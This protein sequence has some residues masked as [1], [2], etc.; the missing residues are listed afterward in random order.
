MST[1][2]IDADILVYRSI[3]SVEREVEWEPDVWTM[4]TDLKEAHE[5]FN[6][7]LFNIIDS[8]P[9]KDFKLCFSDA[10][11]F[12]KEINPSYKSNRAGN[13]KPMGFKPFREQIID[14]HGAITKPALEADDVIGIL[15]TKPGTDFIIVSDD[16]DLRGVPGA[17]LIDG[18]VTNIGE[19]EA[20]LFFYTQVLTG[21]QADGYPGCPGIGPKK[22]EQILA[23]VNPFDNYEVGAGGPHTYWEAV[24]KAYTKAGLTEEDAILQA[25]MARIL[26]WKDWDHENQKV[27]LWTPSN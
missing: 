22:A 19:S 18:H 4:S 9:H 2:L 1:L 12:R 24:V 7:M 23:S 16:K 21:D 3:S 8:S 27:N 10:K 6:D 5:A 11:N 14:K 20:D 17:H 25:R 15:A 26:R 13:R